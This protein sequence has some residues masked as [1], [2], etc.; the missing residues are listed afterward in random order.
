MRV[1]AEPQHGIIENFKVRH[2]RVARIQE[3]MLHTVSKIR[4]LPFMTSMKEAR[5][6]AC[7]AYNGPQIL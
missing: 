5:L 1:T 2:G 6:H 3:T 4:N 7:P